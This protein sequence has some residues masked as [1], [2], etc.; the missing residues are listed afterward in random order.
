VADLEVLTTQML[1]L[2]LAMLQNQ[3]ISAPRS[4]YIAAIDA[5]NLSYTMTTEG[6]EPVMRCLAPGR[7]IAEGTRADIVTDLYGTKRSTVASMT[8]SFLHITIPD[9]L[10]DSLPVLMDTGAQINITNRAKQATTLLPISALRGSGED[11]Y[12]YQVQYTYGGILSTKSLKVVKVPVTVIERSSTTVSIAEDLEG[13]NL[14]VREDRL[15]TDGQTVMLYV[16]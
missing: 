5:G 7:S 1:D 2:D 11:T 14:A 4:G 6:C 9:A 10:T 12:V 8:G 16:N 13:D 3:M 15:L